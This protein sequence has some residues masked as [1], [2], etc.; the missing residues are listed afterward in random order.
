MANQD[1]KQNSGEGKFF[2]TGM[3]VHLPPDLQ[4]KGKCPYLLNVDPDTTLGTLNPRPGTANNVFLGG[5]AYPINITY[6]NSGSFG[7]TVITNIDGSGQIYDQFYTALGSFPP[8]TFSGKPCSMVTYRPPNTPAPYIYVFDAVSCKRIGYASPTALVSQVGLYPPN[9]APLMGKVDVASHIWKPD[10]TYTS[11]WVDYPGTAGPP[12]TTTVIR[13]D[14]GG[15]TVGNIVDFRTFYGWIGPLCI[16]PIGTT[17]WTWLQIGSTLYVNEAGVGVNRLHCVV[18]DVFPE[19]PND[20]VAAISYDTGSTGMCTIQLTNTRQENVRMGRI[21]KV[22]IAVTAILSISVA[23]D[24]SVSIRCLL[25]STHVAGD[26]I[27]LAF[28]FTTCNQPGNNVTVL[29]N[30]I[31]AY[32]VTSDLVYSVTGDQVAKF[33][34]ATGVAPD[35]QACPL[36]NADDYIHWSFKV[37]DPLAVDQIQLVFSTDPLTVL[38]VPF[39]N[40]Y[41]YINFIQGSYTPNLNSNTLTSQLALSEFQNTLLNQTQG[42]LNQIP[43]GNSQWFEAIFRISDLTQVGS[44]DASTIQNMTAIGLIVYFNANVTITWGSIWTSQQSN[45]NLTPTT[46]TIPPST[47]TLDNTRQGG[48]DSNWNSYGYQGTPIQYRY[49]YRDSVTG[50]LSNVSPETRFGIVGR[51]S[52][53]F[54]KVTSSGIPN[55]YIDVE[56]FGGT[57]ASWRRCQTVIDPGVDVVITDNISESNVSTAQPLELD[58]FVPFPTLQQP[59]IG[60]LNVIGTS[61]HW[62]SGALFNVNWVRGTEIIINSRPYSLYRQPTSTT[63]MELEIGAVSVS[64]GTFVFSVPE[65]LIAG[66]NLPYAAGPFDGR[67]FACGDPINRGYLYF[68]NIDNPDTAAGKGY[69]EVTGPDVPLIG[70][71]VYEGA[72]FVFT[73]NS[74]WRVEPTPGA[75][76]PYSAYKLSGSY[77]LGSPQ[78]FDFRG[79]TGYYGT[80]EGLVKFGLSGSELISWADL[81]PLFPFDGHNGVPLVNVATTLYPVDYSR[82]PRVSYA[83][84][85]VY[86]DYIDT[87]GAT[88]CFVYNTLTQGFQ[89]YRYT[90]GS[91][92]HY[93]QD[94]VTNP[95]LFILGIVPPGIYHVDGSAKDVN[96]DYICQCV[97]PALDQ[98]ITR[99]NKNYYDVM[100]DY[101]QSEIAPSLA[102]SVYVNNYAQTTS[103]SSLLIG[104]TGGARVQKLVDL[105]LSASK[106][107]ITALNIGALFTWTASNPV[108]LYEWQPS[109]TPVP[110]AY[111]A[112]PYDWTDCGTTHYKWIQGLRMNIDT[113]GVTKQFQVY[114]GISTPGPI[115]S[116]SSSIATQFVI[117][118]SFNPPFKSHMVKLVPLGSNPASVYSVDWIFNLEPDVATH[119]ETQRSG[120]GLEGFGHAREFQIAYAATG[121]SVFSVIVDGL[122]YP[123]FTDSTGTSGLEVK[124]Y[125]TLPPLKGKLWALAYTGIG[126]Q[127]YEKDCEFRV[128]QWA[129]TGPYKNANIAGDDSLTS[130]AKI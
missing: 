46:V 128:K 118:V 49:R 65:P 52:M 45:I 107:P 80:Q 56:R 11:T 103:V 99:N 55:I 102:I 108:T 72:L 87:N 42:G 24:D 109:F 54:L 51:R 76:N 35:A 96:L 88:F 126:L 62:V 64:Q 113:Y 116:V 31:T 121:T 84:G 8:G 83:E 112:S 106:S 23:A 123:I 12:F 47:A 97:T 117:P 78:M 82:Y 69:I 18:D 7:F 14:P 38:P 30:T 100:V 53:V 79:P 17:D 67:I 6:S 2:Y 40:N 41:W 33:S 63:F 89:H 110:V 4:P 92:L 50:A 59:V 124:Q 32:A 29:G 127:V 61:C 5:S 120:L 19:I 57:L 98:G 60:T 93:L 122:T 74:V 26:T 71:A 37:S 90:I 43:S 39:D 104:S 48:P 9:V 95:N 119:Y 13:R 66:I 1:I 75:V 15:V 111:G 3:N 10:S 129:S 21:I 20:T 85:K 81:R 16:Q 58:Q 70:V 125:A 101:Q 77:G 114:Y 105:T 91:S 73:S 94:G 86:L 25:P 130:G 36:T 68:T 115:F 28:C 34:C 27:T 44:A 22:G